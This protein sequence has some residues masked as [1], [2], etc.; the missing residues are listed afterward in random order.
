MK[1]QLGSIFRSLGAALVSPYGRLLVLLTAVGAVVVLMFREQFYLWMG[2]SAVPLLAWAGAFL[3]LLSVKPHVLREWPRH[4]FAGLLL[5]VAASAALGMVARP[6]AFYADESL[7]GRVGEL[8]ARWP[9][10]WDGYGVSFGQ[11]FL[12]GTRVAV[13][14]ALALALVLPS[15]ARRTGVM[16]GMGVMWLGIAL[17]ALTRQIW[18]GAA[19]KLE[20]RGTED[21][22]DGS[23]PVDPDAEMPAPSG[24]SGDGAS[25]LFAEGGAIAADDPSVADRFAAAGASAGAG[26]ISGN[27][28]AGESAGAGLLASNGRMTSSYLAENSG[29]FAARGAGAAVATDAAADPLAHDRGGAAASS[30]LDEVLERLGLPR[31]R[32][33]IAVANDLDDAQEEPEHGPAGAAPSSE[34]DEILERLGLPRE[35]ATETAGTNGSGNGAEPLANQLA[36][37]HLAPEHMH[38]EPF[39]TAA[40]NGLDDAMEHEELEHVEP[41]DLYLVDQDV[42]LEDHELSGADEPYEDEPYEIVDVMDRTDPAAPPPAPAPLPVQHAAPL[43]FYWELPSM[44]LLKNASGGGV[45]KSEIEATGELIVD[46]LRQHR[47]DVSVDQVRIGPTVTMYGLKPGW[48]GGSGDKSGGQRV[49]VDTIL[50]REKD[51]ALA[52]ASPNLRFEAPVPGESVVGIEVPNE[53]PTPVTLRSVMATGEYQE[54]G[55]ELYLPAP[56][57][58]DSGG[59]PAIADLSKMPHLLVAGSTGS[60]KSVCI[61]TLIVGLLMTRT[62]EQVRMVMIDPKRVELT[63]YAGIPHLYTEPVVEAE[64]AI[65]ILR[66]LVQ[67]MMD[68]FQQLQ[69]AGVRNIASF[70][71]KSENKM[72]YLLI[73]VDELADLMLTG[74]NEVERLLVRL[75]QLGRATGVHLVVATQRPSV[76]VVTGLIKAN[77]PSRISFS[78]MSQVDS[79]TIID[80]PGAEKLLGKGDML[81]LPVDRAKPGRVQGAFLSDSEVEAVVEYWRNVKRPE[82]PMLDVNF[83]SD[84]GSPEMEQSGD[85]HFDSA[86]ALARTQRTL[87]TSL[88]QRK[89]RIGYPRAARLMDELEEEGVV[90]PGEP[91]KARQVVLT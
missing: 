7:G 20:E 56:L 40:T 80:S 33:G 87:S 48:K 53:N 71:Q 6:D 17:F 58:I 2:W 10:E 42:D 39:E 88:L 72:P 13:L 37:E 51:L 24:A 89:L 65:V 61:N 18:Q 50:N 57:G 11:Y 41:D 28:A 29:Q 8:V 38:D 44:S 21:P 23:A 74:A 63:P 30:E 77:F 76:D 46:S 75:A 66:S 60:G 91:G 43:P 52:L 35:H 5:A 12:S 19:E 26:L 25:A 49:R 79:R 54:V 68:R 85:S 27:R 90:G 9:T 69:S 67:E 73:L 55:N 59:K 31:Q 84:S 81:F 14:A 86:V 34:L 36:D 4:V 64:R 78:V 70:N 47:I 1:S 16:A 32:P 82:L 15:A 45:S 83:D 3:F 22:A 62:P